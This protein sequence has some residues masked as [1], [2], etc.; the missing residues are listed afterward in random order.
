M[1]L[2]S[3]APLLPTPMDMTSNIDQRS[4]VIDI[5]VEYSK[6]FLVIQLIVNL[7][8]VILLFLINIIYTTESQQNG[9]KIFI[10]LETGYKSKIKVVTKSLK[11]F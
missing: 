5:K 3:L 2:F 8:L 10:S 11:L 7:G 6:V 1:L 4:D 9:W